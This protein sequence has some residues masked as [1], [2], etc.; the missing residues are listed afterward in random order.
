M[1]NSGVFTDAYREKY[2]DLAGDLVTIESQM[3]L[4][5]FS[6]GE[7]GYQ[8]VGGNKVPKTPDPTKTDIE[9]TIDAVP[10]SAT[11]SA[12]GVRFVKALP[13]GSVSVAGNQVTIVCE[14]D[15]AE[16]DLDGN[17]HLTGNLG[18]DPEI[19]ELGIYDGD[20]AAGSPYTGKATLM[21][22]CTLNEIVKIAGTAVTI[23]VVIEM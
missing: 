2:A 6:V 22:Y 16:A 8:I 5:Y 1:A 14:L 10:P 17:S 12:T 4:V 20:P 7:G 3:P 11:T 18:G 19:F 9:A 21:A 13:G 15:A 23:T